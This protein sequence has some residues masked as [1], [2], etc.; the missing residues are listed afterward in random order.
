MGQLIQQTA[1]AEY[2]LVMHHPNH[3]PAVYKAEPPKPANAPL[4]PASSNPAGTFG[5]SV[6]MSAYL[7][8]VTVTTAD[9][10]AQYAAKGYCRAGVSDPAA[11]EAAISGRP[12]QNSS[13]FHAYPK[14][15]YHLTLE[16][17][18]VNSRDEEKAL[19]AGWADR[20]DLVKTMDVKTTPPPA[21]EKQ[22]PT[23]THKTARRAK[24]KARRVVSPETRAKL[25]ELMKARRA[26]QKT[27]QPTS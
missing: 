14:W 19:G 21:A 12:L 20:P 1:F 2:P 15:K 7:P 3:R 10:E 8:D 25:S 6:G 16:A 11:Y 5:G 23:I 24:K 13:E 18:V 4:I 22:A 26:A 17:C 27:E 9:E